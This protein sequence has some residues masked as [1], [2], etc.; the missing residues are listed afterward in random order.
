MMLPTKHQNPYVET[1]DLLLCTGSG[2]LTKEPAQ[3]VVRMSTLIWTT[4]CFIH[5]KTFTMPQYGMLE[6]VEHQNAVTTLECHSCTQNMQLKCVIQ[7]AR[8]HTEDLLSHP[9]VHN[10]PPKARETPWKTAAPVIRGC[11]KIM[12]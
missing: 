4:A 1:Y 8:T 11:Q 3:I 2:S 5:L 10:G 12:R 6:H 9:S 7:D